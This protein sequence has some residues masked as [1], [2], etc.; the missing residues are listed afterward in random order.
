MA[1]RKVVVMFALCPLLLCSGC[2]GRT[3]YL[4]NYHQGFVAGA[5]FT[6]QQQRRLLEAYGP[7]RGE[8]ALKVAEDSIAGM[9]RDYREWLIK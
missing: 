9:E 3:A 8:A 6:V 7:C 2:S 1:V 5:R 4:R